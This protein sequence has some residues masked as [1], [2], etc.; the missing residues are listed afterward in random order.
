[1]SLNIKALRAQKS[2]TQRQLADKMGV[3]RGTIINWERGFTS[4]NQEELDKLHNI[5]GPQKAESGDEYRDKYYALLEKY[6]KCLED[7]A[8]DS[9]KNTVTASD[10]PKL[11]KVKK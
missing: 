5:F 10:V 2:L 7:Q 6:N 3:S 11:S 9:K 4:P 1:M 8:N